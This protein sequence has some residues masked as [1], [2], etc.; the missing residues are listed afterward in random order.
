MFIAWTSYISTN[1]LNVYVCDMCID[2]Q[3][4]ILEVAIGPIDRHLLKPNPKIFVHRLLYIWPW[5]GPILSILGIRQKEESFLSRSKYRFS[6]NR[7]YGTL[8]ISSICAFISHFKK[9]FSLRNRMN[10]SKVFCWYCF[11]HSAHFNFYAN[12]CFC[13]V[14][15]EWD[16][17]L[18]V[19]LIWWSWFLQWKKNEKRNIKS[20]KQ[21]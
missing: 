3:Y 12:I 18:P 11:N 13:S 6:N 17:R 10:S 15:S 7:K 14:W 19:I 5:N 20:T 9:S 8:S 2:I 4:S 16:E 21:C 1:Q